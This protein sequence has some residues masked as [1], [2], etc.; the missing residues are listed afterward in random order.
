MRRQW[1]LPKYARDGGRLHSTITRF[2]AVSLIMNDILSSGL[3][4]CLIVQIPHRWILAVGSRPFFLTDLAGGGQGVL[5]LVFNHIDRLRIFNV[6]I[7]ASSWELMC[8]RFL[9]LPAPNLEF[10]HVFSNI[11]AGHL[12]HPLFNNHA[13]NLQNL[14]LL[15]CSVDFTSP[16]LTS[17]TELYVRYN[18]ENPVPTVLEWLDILGGMPSL[19]WVTL[20]NA[21]SSAPAN[22]ICPVIHLGVLEMLS[23]DARFYEG[24]T[25]VDH[26]IVPPRCGLRLCC[27]GADVGFDQRKLLAIIEKKLDSWG[28]NDP[29][30][31]LEASSTPQHVAIGYSPH[32]RPVWITGAEEVKY[33]R[34]IHLL[35]P[36]LTI[37]LYFSTRQDTV[38]L[39][40]TLFALFERTFFNTTSL[41]LLIDYEADDGAEVFLPLVDSFRGFVN[42]EKLSLAHDSSSKFLFPLL[43]HSN[44]VLPPAL[45]IESLEFSDASFYSTSDSFLRVADFLQW[46]R[47]QGFPVQEIEIVE[48]F[49]DRRYILTHWHLKDTVVKIY[50]SNFTDSDSDDD[51][52]DLS[53]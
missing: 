49:I 31:H 5:E 20:F 40:L 16:V 11:I 24:V 43:Q 3:R 46:R 8:S 39:F 34:Y 12:A 18:T 7:R 35:D 41:K 37:T 19:R 9:Q 22:G 1:H 48:S 38:P 21:I 47:E 27:R 23:V 45:K 6:N 13:P 33:Q 30:R 26:L 52:S 51:Y 15:R 4:Y 25:L 32:L 17:L 44:P 42:L 36:V 2:G 14:C 29:N 50:D 53:V 28:K 10:M